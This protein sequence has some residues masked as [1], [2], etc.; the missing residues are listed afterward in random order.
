MFESVLYQ[1]VRADSTHLLSLS[2]MTLQQLEIAHVG[3]I[4]TMEIGIN[5]G[6]FFP[7]GE[8]IV[9]H[10]STDGDFV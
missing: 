5:Q 2:S 4:Y 8:L 7:P 3:S 6:Y 1:P 9:N 10:L